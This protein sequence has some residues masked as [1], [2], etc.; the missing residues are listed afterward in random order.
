MPTIFV[1]SL[2]FDFP[3]GWSS[4]KYDDWSYYRNC[5]ISM[6]D[7]IKA[8]DIVALDL[9]RTAWFIEVKDYRIHQRTNPSEL[10]QEFACKVFD[11]LAALLPTRINGREPAE[12]HMASAL[13]R[14]EKLRLVLHIEQPRK[15]SALRPRAI[16]PAAV[17]QQLKRLLKAIDAHPLVTEIGRMSTV[18]W[19]VT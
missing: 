1:D 8:V 11:T 7:G 14:A 2:C 19:S 9:D 5:F 18:A 15:H 10:S 17:R 12:V 16:D 13:L 6:W 4:S 3:A